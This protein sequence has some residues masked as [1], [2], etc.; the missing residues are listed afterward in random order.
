MILQPEEAECV[1]LRAG[2]TLSIKVNATCSPG[3]LEYCW[4]L[5]EQPLVGENSSKLTLAKITTGQRGMYL[6][7]CL[8][9]HKVALYMQATTVAG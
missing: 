7:K 2:E 4:F 5:D 3:A 1:V 9:P 8:Q 6:M